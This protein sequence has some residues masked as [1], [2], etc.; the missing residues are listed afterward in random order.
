MR[1]PT[2]LWIFNLFLFVVFLFLCYLLIIS[3]HR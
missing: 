1:R 2:P 3:G